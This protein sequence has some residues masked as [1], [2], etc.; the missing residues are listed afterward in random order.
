L[1]YT[2]QQDGHAFYVLIF[3]EANTTWVFDVATG[4][5]HERAGWVNGSF[6]RHRSNC[7]MSFNN[8]IVVGDFQN[9]NIYA[10][11]LDFYKDHDAVQRWLR[12]WRALPTSANNLKR[13]AQH[14]LQLDAESGGVDPTELINVQIIDTTTGEDFLLQEDGDDILLEIPGPPD[15][16]L[17]EDGFELLQ[18]DGDP[19]VVAETTVADG[20]IVLQTGQLVADQLDPQVMLRWSDDGGHTWS[21]EHWRSMGKAGE[22]GYRVFWRRLGMTE[23]LRDRVY[24]VSGTDPIQLAIMGA[25]LEL[26]GSSS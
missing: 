26:S 15:V 18:E 8:E 9:G 4:L 25:E 19:I 21:N 7:Q 3:P 16:L 14:T 2:Y 24:E 11:D 23:K 10:L 1:A 5:W 12:T 20:K 13:T 17:Q 6:T 22:W